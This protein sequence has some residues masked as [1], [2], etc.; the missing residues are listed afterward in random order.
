LKKTRHLLGFFVRFK[1]KGAWG[2]DAIRSGFSFQLSYTPWKTVAIHTKLFW[3]FDRGLSLRA[4][5]LLHSSYAQS[6][7]Q[8]PAVGANSA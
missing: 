8:A 7:L 3:Q 2:S 4:N 5:A 6:Q 1:G